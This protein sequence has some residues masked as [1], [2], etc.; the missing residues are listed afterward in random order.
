MSM[1]PC[2][3]CNA[4]TQG[5]H[6]EDDVTIKAAEKRVRNSKKDVGG[7]NNRSKKAV[8]VE[9]C[10]MDHRQEPP[11]GCEFCSLIRNGNRG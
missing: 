9:V 10:K 11:D 5:E 8:M 4:N 1:Q 3:S 2:R 6:S 7:I